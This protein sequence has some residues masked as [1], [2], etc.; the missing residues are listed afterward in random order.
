ML[1]I[2]NIIYI[3]STSVSSPGPIHSNLVPQ[4]RPLPVS[5]CSIPPAPPAA[6]RARARA[7]DET[8]Q[9]DCLSL[10]EARALEPRKL[11][12]ELLMS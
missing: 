7:L 10:I 8:H 9:A 4:T 6:A 5:S 3:T 2:I 1:Y 12:E 11:K